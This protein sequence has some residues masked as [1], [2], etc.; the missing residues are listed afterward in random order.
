M[1]HFR[2]VLTGENWSTSTCLLCYAKWGDVQRLFAVD[3]EHD[4]VC[5]QCGKVDR[6]P[7]AA[8]WIKTFA[9]HY[10][11][12]GE[13]H[14]VSLRSDDEEIRWVALGSALPDKKTAEWAADVEAR[15]VPSRSQALAQPEAGTPS[16]PVAEAAAAA[17]DALT[18]RDGVAPVPLKPATA[19]ATH[20]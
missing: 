16:A 17:P 6:D 7:N 9:M 18:A 12:T 13:A 20:C 1:R 14:P 11:A 19:A 15:R 3:K 10:A 5:P 8:G 4:K 2:V